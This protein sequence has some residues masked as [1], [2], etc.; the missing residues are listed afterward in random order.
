MKDVCEPATCAAMLLLKSYDFNHTSG[1][2]NSLPP[3]EKKKGKIFLFSQEAIGST[4]SQFCWVRGDVARCEWDVWKQWI[5]MEGAVNSV[6]VM[7]VMVSVFFFSRIRRKLSVQCWCLKSHSL[8]KQI[9]EQL[10]HIRQFVQTVQRDV[11]WERER[12]LVFSRFVFVFGLGFVALCSTAVSECMQE[13]VC[14]GWVC[15]YMCTQRSSSETKEKGVQR[16]RNLT[17][18]EWEMFVV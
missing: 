9:H 17:L 4:R 15:V 5:W 2:I 3:Q 11:K 6:N 13:A 7:S 14:L 16:K 8:G 10:S 18:I 12:W 1:N